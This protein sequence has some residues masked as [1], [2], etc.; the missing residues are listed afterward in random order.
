MT[1]QF[2]GHARPESELDRRERLLAQRREPV[3]ANPVSSHYDDP[4]FESLLKMVKEDFPDKV[5]Y[6][7]QR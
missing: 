3:V 4:M 2:K 1:T 6:H 5:G 7:G